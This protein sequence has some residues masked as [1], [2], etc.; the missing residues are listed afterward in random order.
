MKLLPLL[1]SGLTLKV[2]ATLGQ[3]QFAD[4]GYSNVIVTISPDVNPDLADEIL[5][6]T[7]VILHPIWVV[8]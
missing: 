7:K 8:H 3:I 6:G 4:N 2:T 5:N 1:L